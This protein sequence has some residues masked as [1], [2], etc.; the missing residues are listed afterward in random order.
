MDVIP[1]LKAQNYQIAIIFD[2]YGRYIPSNASRCACPAGRLFCSHMLG[3]FLVLYACQALSDWSAQDLL[4][5][6]PEP[7]KILQAIPILLDQAWDGIM[8]DFNVKKNK[9]KNN[10]K[11]KIRN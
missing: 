8:K 4:T 1:S 2:A 11:T 5:L 10:L 3:F 9:G 6:F 7:V